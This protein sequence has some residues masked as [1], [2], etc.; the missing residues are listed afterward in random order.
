M[1]CSLMVISSISYFAEGAAVH[2][3]CSCHASTWVRHVTEVWS[4][5]VEIQK[6]SFESIGLDVSLCLLPHVLTR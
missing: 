5:V 1:L 3:G 2:E 4:S 6:L